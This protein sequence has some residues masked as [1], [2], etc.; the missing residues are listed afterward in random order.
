MKINSAVFIASNT[1]PDKCPATN[2]PEYALLGRSNVGKSSLINMI[3]NQ[4]RL[5]KT[6]STPGKTNLINHFLINDSWY[7]VDLPGFGYAKTSKTNIRTFENLIFKYLNSR[8]NLMTVFLLIDSRIPPQNID[9]EMINF[10][11]ENK[12]P[13]VILF[14]KIDGLSKNVLNNNLKTYQNIL[15]KL[16]KKI[17]LFICTSAKTIKGKTEI[18][19]Y[20]DKTNTSFTHNY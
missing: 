5:A 19:E 18:L 9:L 16:Y 3:T 12:I 20:I 8:S 15:N 6:S 11:E 13:F 1:D 14:T 2:K 4:K 10:M 17:P 7:F